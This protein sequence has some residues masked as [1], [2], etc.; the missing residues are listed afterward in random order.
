MQKSLDKY[1]VG[2]VIGMCITLAFG[3]FYI[4]YM[5]LYDSI[6]NYGFYRVI[7]KMTIISLFPNTAL[8]F[9]LYQ[10]DYWKLAKG[11]VISMIPYILVAAWF[12]I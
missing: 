3:W 4:D 1:W 8:L 10:F 12:S 9:L 5:S 2:I 7:P 6:F 11:I